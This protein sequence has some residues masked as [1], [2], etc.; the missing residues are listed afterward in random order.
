MTAAGG[1]T[2]EGKQ[3]DG[4]GEEEEVGRGEEDEER[5]GGAA[6]ESLVSSLI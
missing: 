1:A 5:R 2:E 3:V 4:R 6:A